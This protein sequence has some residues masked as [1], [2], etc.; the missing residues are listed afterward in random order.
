MNLGL[1]LISRDLGDE[2]SENRVAYGFKIPAS[3]RFT[4]TRQFYL[5]TGVRMA[6]NFASSHT[7]S[8]SDF[9][10][11]SVSV[12]ASETDG[13]VWE[14]KTF[15]PSLI[16]GLGGTFR[17]NSHHDFDIG[18]RFNLDVGGIEKYDDIYLTDG[19]I[20]PKC[21]IYRLFS[22]TILVHRYPAFNK[23]SILPNFAVLG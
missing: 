4:P 7:F 9:Y 12:S 3:I 1:V 11:N 18:A 13:F 23:C 20:K 14:A 15:V 6:F 2:V 10:G 19:K 17:E 22:I 16:F 8:G 21:G 5:E